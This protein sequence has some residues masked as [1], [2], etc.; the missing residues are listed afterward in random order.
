MNCD[1]Y[2]K[3]ISAGC[4]APSEKVF[5]VAFAAGHKSLQKGDRV[6]MRE[7]SEYN[8]CFLRLSDLTIHTLRNEYGD[9]Y[10]LVVEEKSDETIDSIVS[11]VQQ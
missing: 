7:D 9:G 3:L 1:C 8:N 4:I 2:D 10:V 11:S 5:I 6:V